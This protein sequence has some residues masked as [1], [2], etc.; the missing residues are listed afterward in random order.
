MN[1]RQARKARK[2]AKLV[3]SY[4]GSRAWP[5][6]LYY[7]LLE[8]GYR[9]PYSSYVKW[10]DYHVTKPYVRWERKQILDGNANALID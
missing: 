8:V 6:N 9:P 10:Y 3:M 4:R 5:L 1:R 2:V 7:E